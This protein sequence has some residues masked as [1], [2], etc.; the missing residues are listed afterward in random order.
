MVS[1][2]EEGEWHNFSWW[3]RDPHEDYYLVRFEE[4]WCDKMDISGFALFSLEEYNGWMGAM[5]ELKKAMEKG[6][7]FEY[8]FGTN[9]FNEYEEFKEFSDCF[10]AKILPREDALVLRNAFDMKTP[11]YGDFPTADYINCYLEDMEVCNGE[12]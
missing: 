9:E 1:W 5:S 6:L 11:Y 10:T 12:D 2:E 7:T 4:N 3:E 8:H